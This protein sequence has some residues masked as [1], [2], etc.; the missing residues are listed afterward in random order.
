MYSTVKHP[1]RS[2]ALP[3]WFFIFL[4]GTDGGTLSAVRIHAGGRLV[5]PAEYRQLVLGSR[6]HG[7]FNLENTRRSLMCHQLSWYMLK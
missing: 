2:Q 6:Q 1:A 4:G 5:M 3:E 7:K